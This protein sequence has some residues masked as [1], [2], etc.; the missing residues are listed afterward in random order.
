MKTKEINKDTLK[1]LCSEL[2]LQWKFDKDTDCY[3]ASFPRAKIKDNED[4]ETPLF[5]YDPSDDD[6]LFCRTG[7]KLEYNSDSN[8]LKIMWGEEEEIW[9]LSDLRKTCKNMIETYNQFQ[10]YKKQFGEN[11]RMVK[12][13]KDFE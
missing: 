10:L 8:N 6:Y 1:K 5:L 3:Y 4:Y 9:D 13:K 12:M 11:K 2:G 7:M